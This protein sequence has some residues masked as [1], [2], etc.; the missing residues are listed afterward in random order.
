MVPDRI[1]PL[2]NRG[3]QEN[4]RYVLYW[5]QQSQRADHNPALERALRHANEEGLPLLVAFGLMDD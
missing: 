1:Q 2:N 5:M 4:G 3:V